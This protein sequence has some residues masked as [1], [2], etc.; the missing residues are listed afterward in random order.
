MAFAAAIERFLFRRATIVE[1]I[2]LWIA[3]VG[4]LWPEDWVDA[5]GFAALAAAVVLQ[6]RPGKA[7]NE[8]P[9]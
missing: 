8:D 4:L 5:V 1:S 6:R 7:I 9:A 2:L 3:T